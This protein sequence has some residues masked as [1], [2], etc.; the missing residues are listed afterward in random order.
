MTG[1][2]TPE[3]TALIVRE[4]P[5][6]G[7]VR[8]ILQGDEYPFLNVAVVRDIRPTKA[9][10]HRGFDEIYF[11]LDGSGRFRIGDEERDVGSGYAVLA[12]AGL[13]HAVRNPGPGR[14]TLLVFMARTRAPISC[15]AVINGNE[16]AHADRRWPLPII[17][18]RIKSPS[19][20]AAA[21]F[22]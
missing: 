13:S 7:E 22:R 1:F 14:L 11:V 17:A 2:A 4:S 15:S 21:P 6:C 10:Y 3:K 12:P 20:E 16:G 5:T 18:I 9:H 19:S 8:G